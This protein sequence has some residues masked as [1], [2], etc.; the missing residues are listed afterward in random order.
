MERDVSRHAILVAGTFERASSPEDL[1]NDADRVLDVLVGEF[2]G[3]A[4]GPAV[5]CDFE[6]SVIDVRFSVEAET[7]AQVH[8][9]I[10]EISNKI[11]ESIGGRVKTATSPADQ[12]EA[13]CA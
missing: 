3:V 6:G 8:Q 2:D 9:Q 5:G 7:S 4:I 12:L 1:E 13:A 10:S 11:D